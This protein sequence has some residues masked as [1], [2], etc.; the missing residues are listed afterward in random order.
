MDYHFFANHFDHLNLTKWFFLYYVMDIIFR[1]LNSIATLVH[2][3]F[4]TIFMKKKYYF[5]ERVFHLFIT[6]LGL[7][8]Y[9]IQVI[10]YKQCK[11]TVKRLRYRR[12]KNQLC[13]KIKYKMRRIDLDERNNTWQVKNQTFQKYLVD[14]W[15]PFPDS[16]NS[17]LI[18]N[19]DI[20]DRK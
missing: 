11:I 19:L 13:Y 7:Y 18:F 6:R 4:V 12:P 10:C 2:Y 5:F 14:L 1:K 16:M 3:L 9:K 17:N 8:K 15:S 20:W